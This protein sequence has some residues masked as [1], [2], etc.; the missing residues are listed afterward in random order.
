LPE[1]VLVMVIDTGIRRALHASEYNARREECA[2]AV[3]VLA[4]KRPG[5]TSLRDVLPDD[6]PDMETLL[7]QKL[8]RRVRHVVTENDR[9]LRAADALRR[10]DAASLGSLLYG[11]HFSLRSDYEVSCPEL[12]ALVDICAECDCVLGARMTGAGFGGS[13]VC[14][15]SERGAREVA[16][17]VEVE[18]PD[19]TG[20]NATTHV[21]SVEDGVLTQEL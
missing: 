20:K 1:D 13:V 11:S 16:A 5:L 18:Y 17:R 12:D 3:R 6:L 21:C 15:A 7:D 4:L 9:V 19:K 14:L 8:L 2:E 10:G